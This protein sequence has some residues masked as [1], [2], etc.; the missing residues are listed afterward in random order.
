MIFLCSMQQILHQSEIKLLITGAGWMTTNTTFYDAVYKSFLE[1]LV[2]AL[3]DVTSDV[4]EYIR[5]GRG[6][7]PMYISP[8]LPQNIATTIAVIEKANLTKGLKSRNTN[9]LSMER[10]ILSILDQKIFPH[11]RYALEHGVGVLSYDSSGYY[12][13]QQNQTLQQDSLPILV[14]YLLLAAFICHTNRQ[15]KDRQLFSIERN[16]RKRR[17]TKDATDAEEEAAYGVGSKTD[18]P[19]TIRPRTFPMER[20]YSL[21]VSIVSLNK[22]DELVSCFSNFRNSDGIVMDENEMSQSLG[23]VPFLETIT[24]LRDMG[25]LH[26]YPKRSVTDPIRVSQ[27]TLWT[28]ITRD[29]AQRI[30]TSIRFPL[31]RYILE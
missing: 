7:W 12:T 13:P 26:D 25:V 10:D 14:K 1:T 22:S 4:K 20:L 28:S 15:D 3:S 9:L 24:Y 17:K 5:L 21:Y 23:S 11:I 2:Q 19:K 6:L 29:E 18:A 27:R 8:V 16:G 31:D 30:A